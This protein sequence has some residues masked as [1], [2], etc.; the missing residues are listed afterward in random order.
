MNKSTTNHMGAKVFPEVL[1]FLMLVICL[2][3]FTV[4]FNSAGPASQLIVFMAGQ[5]FTA[6]L[7]CVNYHVG[8]SQSSAAKSEKLNAIIK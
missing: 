3:V 6:L 2:I 8:T 5:F 4:I 7:I 1:T